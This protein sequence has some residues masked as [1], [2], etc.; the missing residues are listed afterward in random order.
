MESSEIPLINSVQM[1]SKKSSVKGSVKNS[2]NNKTPQEENT[3]R[4][5]V[6]INNKGEVDRQI[7]S[8]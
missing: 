1:K 4:Q 7:E 6:R 5:I 2:R 3:P 8:R